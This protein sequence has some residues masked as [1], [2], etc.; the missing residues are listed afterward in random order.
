MELLH[1]SKVGGPGLGER[2]LNRRFFLL[3][4]AA[5]GLPLVVPGFFGRSSAL[6][7]GETVIPAIDRAAPAATQTATFAMG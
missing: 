2:R 6:G 7:A 1:K 3:Q 4:T 5:A